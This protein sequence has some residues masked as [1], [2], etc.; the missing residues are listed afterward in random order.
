MRDDVHSRVTSSVPTVI[1]SNS[2]GSN[3]FSSRVQQV[4]TVYKGGKF[5]FVLIKYFL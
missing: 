2:H 4:R 3:T 1:N 5:F